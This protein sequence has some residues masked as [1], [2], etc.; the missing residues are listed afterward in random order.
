MSYVLSER[1]KIRFWFDVVIHCMNSLADKRMKV[2][3][4]VYRS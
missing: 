2:L 1:N 3:A 4:F